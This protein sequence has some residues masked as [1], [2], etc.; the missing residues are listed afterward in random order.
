MISGSG[1][2]VVV[3]VIFAAT[4]DICVKKGKVGSVGISLYNIVRDEKRK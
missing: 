2:D 3:S 4:V 1:S